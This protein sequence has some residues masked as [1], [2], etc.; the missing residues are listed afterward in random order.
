MERLTIASF[1]TFSYDIGTQKVYNRGDLI[2][3]HNQKDTDLESQG[4]SIILEGFVD[5]LDMSGEQLCTLG[6]GDFFGEQNF[7]NKTNG[8][9]SLG[10]LR[11]QSA[12][13]RI[14]VVTR[15]HF[16]RVPNFEFNKL[17]TNTSRL[18]KVEQTQMYINKRATYAYKINT[19]L[20]KRKSNLI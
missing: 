2:R 3:R 18:S 9:E 6:R 14:L 1:I 12:T 20:E 8:I 17:R 13:T 4:F 11:A 15:D 7:N 19:K 10:D 16:H 5:V